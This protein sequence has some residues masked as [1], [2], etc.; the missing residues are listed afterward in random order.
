MNKLRTRLGVLAVAVSLMTPLVGS[1]D[2]ALAA[3]AVAGNASFEGTASL[4]FFPCPT[5]PMT[6]CGGGSFSGQWAG[7]MAGHTDGHPF[8]VS[9]QTPVQTAPAI[10][11]SFSYNEVVCLAGVET[12][13]G[14]A[15]GSGSATSDPAHTVGYWYG[16][17]FGELPRAIIGVRLLFNF[18]WF[19]SAN[20]AVVVVKPGSLLEIDI[21]G[22]GWRTVSTSEQDG[23]ASFVPLS[24]SNTVIPGCSTPLTG[25]TGVIAGDLTLR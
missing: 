21:A 20:S 8:D 6:P 10:T 9:W 25:V 19:R 13:S 5:S 22:L 12:L 11:A 18:E 2:P 15:W 1:P 4:P 17:G 16:G 14:T 7:H 23:V 3:S 24:S